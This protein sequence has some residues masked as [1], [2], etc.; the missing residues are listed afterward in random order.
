MW[1]LAN[2]FTPRY[3]YKLKVD[4]SFVEPLPV[5]PWEIV[6]EDKE[7]EKEGEEMEERQSVSSDSD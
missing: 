3:L 6:K 1:P 4:D 2:H 7:K 5:M